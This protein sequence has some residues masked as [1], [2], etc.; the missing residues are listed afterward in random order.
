MIC[1]FLL[2]N[3]VLILFVFL[4]LDLD[5]LDDDVNLLLIEEIL[6]SE[7]SSIVDNPSFFF[8]LFSLF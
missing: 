8:P 2:A 5:E 6:D 1:R 3:L 4:G 7:T